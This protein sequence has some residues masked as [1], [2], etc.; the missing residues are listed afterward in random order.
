MIKG[1]HHV[2]MKCASEEDFSR[3]LEF[4]RDILGLKEYRRWPEGVLQEHSLLG[5]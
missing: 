2:S 4:Y 1:L 3:V 5:I